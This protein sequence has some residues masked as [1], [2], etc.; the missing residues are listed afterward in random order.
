MRNGDLP[1]G[2]RLDDF[3][4]FLPPELI[5]QYPADRRDA[6]RMMVVERATAT[7]K[8]AFFGDIGCYL[9]PGDVLVVND[10]K[11]IPARIL[12]H[13]AESGGQVEVFLVEREPG[14]DEVWKCLCRA[15]KRPHAGSFLILGE[16]LRAEVLEETDGALLRLRFTCN[17]DFPAILEKV[18]HIPLPPYIRRADMPSD[19]ERYQT[20]FARHAGAVAA[21]T[22]GLHFTEDVL[23]KLKVLGVDVAPLTLHVGLGTFLPVRSDDIREHRMHGELFYIPEVTAQKVRLARSEGRRVV[24]VGTTVVRALET[25]ALEQGA[26]TGGGGVSRLFITPGFRFRTVDALLT[27]FHLPKSTLLMLVAAF[28]GRELILEAYRRACAECYRFYSYGD[29]ML[30]V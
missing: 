10:T 26:V 17:G 20:V 3:D 22:A 27:N 7:L 5:A 24:A 16:Q 14:D 23:E 29:C 13:K 21:P 8:D 6:S 4:Y 30:I 18:G 9:R 15:S 12:G 11:V 2:M 28:A 1:Q 25:S 19:R